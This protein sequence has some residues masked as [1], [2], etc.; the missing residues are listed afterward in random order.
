ME[1]ITKTNITENKLHDLYQS[2]NFGVSVQF[3]LS[4]TVGIITVTI[5]VRRDG[6]YMLRSTTNSAY[7]LIMSGTKG[8]RLHGSYMELAAMIKYG[9][10]TMLD[11]STL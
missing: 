8:M 10:Y 7:A 11:R 1:L 3:H 4:T 6:G 2:G 9:N 5:E